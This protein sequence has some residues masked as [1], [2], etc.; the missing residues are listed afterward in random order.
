MIKYQK[1]GFFLPALE[2][3]LNWPCLLSKSHFLHKRQYLIIH[4][5]LKTMGNWLVVTNLF[6]N[7]K[8]VNGEANKKLFYAE[9]QKSKIKF[10]YNTVV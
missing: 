6:N 3:I 2:V 5:R 10:K 8:K 7:V 4:E 1:K 9:S